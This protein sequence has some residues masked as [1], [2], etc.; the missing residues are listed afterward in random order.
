MQDISFSKVKIG[1][2]QRTDVVYALTQ[3]AALAAD[4]Q[5]RSSQIMEGKICISELGGN[6]FRHGNGGRLCVSI[7]KAR[8]YVMMICVTEDHGPGFENIAY[9]TKRGYSTKKSLG[10]GLFTV[11]QQA[12][13][14]KIYN[15]RVGG[16]IVSARYNWP[17]RTLSKQFEQTSP[18]NLLPNEQQKVVLSEYQRIPG[19]ELASLNV[20]H[21]DSKASGDVVLDFKNSNQ[22]FIGIFD[23]LGHGASASKVATKY[24]EH[25]KACFEVFHQSRDIT[26]FLIAINDFH[27][28]SRTGVLGG[29]LINEGSVYII[30][31]GNI[32]IL[33][34]GDHAKEYTS[35]PGIINDGLGIPALEKVFISPG[36]TF[37]IHSDGIRTFSSKVL[38]QLGRYISPRKIVEK[39]HQQ[40]RKPNDDQS[41][42]A[43]R[44]TE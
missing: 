17:V 42:L 15:K 36:H 43:I 11:K 4:L 25:F 39:L 44:F 41:I 26:R 12:K 10:L 32:R 7:R 6:V 27:K 5:L 24:W 1:I 9:S 19:I 8:D 23:A 28:Y 18:R 29:I 30:S 34:F 31:K 40:Y 21:N 16:A 22:R 2:F 35:K 3:F 37:V 20:P 14:L 13:S 38:E 33:C